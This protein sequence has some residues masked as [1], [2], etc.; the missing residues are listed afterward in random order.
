[1]ASLQRL[2]QAPGKKRWLPIA[3]VAAI[4]AGTIAYSV[5]D[6]SDK[7]PVPV[8]QSTDDASGTEQ[9]MQQAYRLAQNGLYR[10]ALN[11]V[12][13]A[14][15]NN[16]NNMDAQ[17]LQAT[18]L[19]KTGKTTEA[20]RRFNALHEQYPE[21][22]EPLNNLAVLYAEAGDSSRAIQTLQKAFKTH[23]SYDQVYQNLSDMYA[24]LAAD[25]YN[26]ALGLSGSENGPQLASLD[27]FGQPTAINA[28]SSLISLA[29]TTQSDTAETT[30]VVSTTPTPLV[31]DRL[32]ETAV[33]VPD[34]EATE[35][36]TAS[37]ESIS[38]TAVAVTDDV[39]SG[40][41]ETVGISEA[42]PEQTPPYT[43]VVLNEADSEAITA[44][45]NNPET[46]SDN[47]GTIDSTVL[48]ASPEELAIARETERA[49][50]LLASLESGA[51]PEAVEEAA[52]ETPPTPEEL[53]SEHLKGWAEA[54]S[55]Q[56]VDG[57]LRAY[58]AGYKPNNTT[59]HKQW[60]DQRRSRLS[61]PTFIKVE[62]SDIEVTM[63]S[64]NRAEATFRQS[65][66]SDRYRDVERKRVSLMRRSSGWK[67]VEEGKL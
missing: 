2:D 38:E 47:N 29:T 67:I 16:A 11:T 32:T 58:V 50:Q 15:A 1:M 24:V 35:Q 44:A 65:Y 13:Q 37:T 31:T 17:L 61:R 4:A 53:V 60:A 14:L 12:N 5:L 36:E 54:W 48:S 30:P 41:A 42:A 43:N 26:K 49:A 59:S 40:T 22:P 55:A 62:L 64:E 19:A 7:Q 46:S 66:R 10:D 51:V 3:I 63:L 21:R 20:E 57:Y 28:G 23:P 25:A 45:Q 39:Q 8:T 52:E 18:L 33:E 56:D 27:R 6:S 9:T 34:N